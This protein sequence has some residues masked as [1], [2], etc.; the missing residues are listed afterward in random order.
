MIAWFA[1]LPLVD[2]VRWSVLCLIFLEIILAAFNLGLRKFLRWQKNLEP[3][4]RRKV[5]QVMMVAVIL[6][7][8]IVILWKVPEWQVANLGL[9]ITSR[10]DRENESQKDGSSNIR[11]RLFPLNNNYCLFKL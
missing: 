6:A 2:Q 8:V 1:Q 4:D 7:A 9:D 5:I 10:F 11:R 3:N